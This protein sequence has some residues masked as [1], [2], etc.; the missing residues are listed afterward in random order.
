MI[1][2]RINMS[3]ACSATVI[4]IVFAAGFL[5]DIPQLWGLNL[6]RFISGAA[7]P[8]VLV[9]AALLMWDTISR[10]VMSRLDRFSILM[11]ERKCLR[12]LMV[13]GIAALA[14]LVFAY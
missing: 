2:D 1:W 5:F 4:M 10:P 13:T 7:A 11:A 8:A 9:L 6:G 14:T 3:T 12:L